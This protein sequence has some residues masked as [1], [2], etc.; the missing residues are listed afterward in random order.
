M[1][2]IT[3]PRFEVLL[4]IAFSALLAVLAMHPDVSRHSVEAPVALAIQDATPRAGDLVVARK[5]ASA[6]RV[7]ERVTPELDASYDHT[8]APSAVIAG[9][10]MPVQIRITNT[11]LRPWPAGGDQP[12]RLGYHWYDA[13]GNTVL[14]DG[15][16]AAL[17]S[18]VASGQATTLDV[19]VR[20]P[21][22]DGTYTLAW[23]L[24]QEGTGWFSGN[25]VAMKT[26]RIVVGDGVTF[27]GKGWGHGVGLSQ[28][29]A[30]GWAEGAV[31]PRLSGEEILA[32]YF[33][34]ADL[35]SLPSAPPFRVLISA[36]SNGCVGRTIGDVARLNSQG[37]MR[38]VSDA[39]PTIVYAVTA[40]GQPLRAARSGGGV[41]VTDEWA[42]R[43]VYAGRDPVTVVPASGG[44]RS[45]SPRRASRTAAP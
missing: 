43:V 31:G 8:T 3:A 25:T 6:A 45:A 9:A 32:K 2:D 17:S 24:V 23:D 22:A 4:G 39:D 38:V 40:P 10:E 35:V 16:G 7:V 19:S 15:A 42:R 14:W 28:W 1:V 13:D 33:P 18:D 20:A 11:G 41:V 12:V 29:G 34:G 5:N 21:L 44:T 36:P 37:G 30:Q 27:Y 26:E